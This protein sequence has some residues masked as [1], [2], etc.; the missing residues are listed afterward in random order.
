MLEGKMKKV[1]SVCSIDK[2]KQLQDIISCESK[3]PSSERSKI[4]RIISQL[5]TKFNIDQQFEQLLRK[6]LKGPKKD[7][8]IDALC[9]K[10][11]LKLSTKER[12]EINKRLSDILDIKS[13]QFISAYMQSDEQEWVVIDTQD[14]KWEII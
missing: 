8:L 13:A 9:G 2:L 3:K 1:L 7:A 4:Q 12:A 14:D 6:N 10:K 11:T 5:E